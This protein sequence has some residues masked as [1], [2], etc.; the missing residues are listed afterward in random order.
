MPPS[1]FIALL[2]SAAQACQRNTGIPASFTIAQAALESAWGARAVG[3]NLFGI[4]ADPAWHGPTVTFGTHENEAGKEVAITDRFRAYP[5][6]QASMEDH[7]AFL[8]ANGHYADCWAQSTGEGWARAIAA[9]H[10][11]TDPGYTD[12]LVT[13][14][15]T[16]GLARLDVPPTTKAIA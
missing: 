1:A 7:A 16:R 2:A 15:R 12:K 13:I 3:N 9:D 4:K 14:I 6:W 10:Y 11:A 5:S 8:R